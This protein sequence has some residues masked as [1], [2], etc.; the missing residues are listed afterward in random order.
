MPTG[1]SVESLFSRLG[2]TFKRFEFPSDNPIEVMGLLVESR[3]RPDFFVLQIG[4][5]DGKSDDPALGNHP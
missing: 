4:A 1:R 2:Y 3:L 5:N